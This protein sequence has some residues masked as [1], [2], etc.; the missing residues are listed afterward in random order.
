[1][2]ITVDHLG[3]DIVVFT[4]KE[5][6]DETINGVDASA[7]IILADIFRR[8]DFPVM[9]PVVV[10][11]MSFILVPVGCV[12]NLSAIDTIP[13]PVVVT[14]AAT[15]L[16]SVP[17]TSPQNTSVCSVGRIGVYLCITPGK[18]T[19]RVDPSDFSRQPIQI[20]DGGAVSTREMSIAKKTYGWKA[21][22]HAGVTHID[23]RG[24]DI[25]AAALITP[26]TSKTT[27]W[28]LGRPVAWAGVLRE[29][30]AV[31]ARIDELS[32]RLAVLA[33]KFAR[34]GPASSV[35]AR[36]ALLARRDELLITLDSYDAE[37]AAAR[38][39]DVP[40]IPADAAIVS[41]PVGA[42]P[43]APV[44]VAA[45]TARV[46][47]LEVLLAQ[48]V[49]P[50][51]PMESV[52]ARIMSARSGVDEAS[53]PADV[54]VWLREYNARAA[55][56][57]SALC[58][59][60]RAGNSARSAHAARIAAEAERARL[61]VAIAGAPSDAVVQEWARYREWKRNAPASVR[62]YKRAAGNR[63]TEARLA[64]IIGERRDV[65]SRLLDCEREIGGN[66]AGCTQEEFVELHKEYYEVLAAQA[67]ANAEY[68][69]H[70]L[71]RAEDKLGALLELVGEDQIVI[72]RTPTPAPIRARYVL[73]CDYP[74]ADWFLPTVD[75]PCGAFVGGLQPA[76]GPAFVMCACGAKYKNP[77][78]HMES[79][80]HKKWA[81]LQI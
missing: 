43:R 23:A 46:A 41:R 72:L 7:H 52:L 59:M 68:K 12:D 42:K 37:I 10:C 77:V 51:P 19:Y 53:A 57:M 1:M 21:V 80:G 61:K 31:M 40:E 50:I 20:G 11:G 22:L 8:S 81:A 76:R 29:H 6:Y 15:M 48:P 16:E 30:V 47:E 39:Y 75:A 54:G 62:D 9:T 73:V 36:A 25:I 79:A 78:K 35:A 33:D 27:R 55:D 67:A 63:Q 2:I 49:A 69:A 24:A 14:P 65:L 28:L 18:K 71:V 13:V 45:M 56:T 64:A 17:L 44:D 38:I 58:D 74:L 32:G 34:A 66:C 3:G 26:Q 5:L 60:L 70:P 4:R